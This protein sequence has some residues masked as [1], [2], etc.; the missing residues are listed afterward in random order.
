M[1]FIH[2]YYILIVYSFL[3]FSNTVFLLWP[4]HNLSIHLQTDICCIHFLANTDAI[5]FVYKYLCKYMPSFPFG[6]YLGVKLLGSMEGV[7]ITLNEIFKAFS[8]YLYHVHSTSI[9][10]EFWLLHILLTSIQS[11]FF[12]LRQ[13]IK[14]V[15]IPYHS[16]ILHFLKD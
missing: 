5:N 13:S 16:F 10:W 2:L 1:S 7:C 12:S 3:F 4:Y 6:K 14:C 11:V 8:K 15:V 9:A